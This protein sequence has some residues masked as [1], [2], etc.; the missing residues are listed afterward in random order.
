MN[1]E[2]LVENVVKAA[3]EWNNGSMAE[4]LEAACDALRAF[5]AAP[6]YVEPTPLTEK[7]GEAITMDEAIAAS[8]GIPL[9]TRMNEFDVWASKM[10]ETCGT[11]ASRVAEVERRL[12]MAEQSIVDLCE[13]DATPAPTEA[14]PFGCVAREKPDGNWQVENAEGTYWWSNTPSEGWQ[15]ENMHMAT[16]RTRESAIANFH[17]TNKGVPPPGYTPNKPARYEV[18]HLGGCEWIVR[19]KGFTAVRARIPWKPNGGKDA[20]RK[21]ALAV[22]ERLNAMKEGQQ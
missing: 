5:D 20:S 14:L 21:I 7:A 13:T 9:D 12:E 1:R 3:M 22:C 8:K 11:L 4:D 10:T 15:S 16:N 18:V 19:L 6:G 17:A 2:Q